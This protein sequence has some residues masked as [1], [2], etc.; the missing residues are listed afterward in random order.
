MNLNQIPKKVE[1]FKK[2]IEKHKK[3][4]EDGKQ[5]NLKEFLK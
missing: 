2:I 1:D 5:K 4:V 3:L